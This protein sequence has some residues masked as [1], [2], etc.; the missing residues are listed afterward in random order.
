[1]E[2]TLIEQIAVK[3]ALLPLEQQR[4]TLHLIES[5][6]KTRRVSN[7]SSTPR[8]LR[9][10]GA[11]AGQGPILTLEVLQEARKEMWG[12]YLETANATHRRCQL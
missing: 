4:L 1:M 9:L 6:A 12:E 5:L 8:H 3:T 2:I 7:G 11:T 10:K